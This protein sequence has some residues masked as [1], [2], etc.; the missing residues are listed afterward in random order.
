M[1]IW[2]DKGDEPLEDNNGLHA[3]SPIHETGASAVDA[4]F[5]DQH[6][7]MAL[8]R[9]RPINGCHGRTGHT[10]AHT[11]ERVLIGPLTGWDSSTNRLA[12]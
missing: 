11:E 10:V 8:W 6:G 3:C 2:Y 4:P 12:C 1:E 5:P 9:P 7:R